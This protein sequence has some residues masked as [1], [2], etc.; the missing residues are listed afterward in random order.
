MTRAL[1]RKEGLPEGSKT[2]AFPT[3]D[4]PWLNRVWY[5]LI[6]QIGELY[7]TITGGIRGGGRDNMPPLGGVLLVSNHLSYLDVFVLG[8]GAN[9]PLNYVAR[10]TLFVPVLGPFIRSVGGFPIQREGMGASGLKETLRRLRNGGVVLLFP[11]GTRSLDG[12]LAELKSGIAVIASRAKVPILPAGVAG[13]FQGWPRNRFY[14]LPHP[15]RVEFGPP[16]MP[17][18]LLGLSTEAITTLIHDR[19]D[20]CYREALRGLDRDLGVESPVP[21]PPS[22]TASTLK[23]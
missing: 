11:E 2:A 22:G 3:H 18:E 10:S 23:G 9:R 17:D 19:I 13:T 5:E 4:R 15:V 20:R 1:R 8:I 21:E 7:F 6:R 16:I 12:R 14:P